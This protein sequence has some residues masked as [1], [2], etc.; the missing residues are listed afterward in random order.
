[1]LLTM[2]STCLTWQCAANVVADYHGFDRK[3]LYAVIKTE[4]GG[5][6]AVKVSRTHDYG[7]AQINKVNISDYKQLVDYKFNIMRAGELLAAIKQKGFRV[8]RYNLGLGI[9]TAGRELSCS[10]YQKKLQKF[11]Y[12]ARY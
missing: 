1:M 3:L 12:V 4:S 5:N 7:I 6:V 2:L 10:I 9:M 11:G 8:C